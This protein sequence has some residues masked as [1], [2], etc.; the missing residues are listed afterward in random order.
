MKSKDNNEFHKRAKEDL[1]D[2]IKNIWQNHIE[3]VINN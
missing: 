2:F 3:N 1:N